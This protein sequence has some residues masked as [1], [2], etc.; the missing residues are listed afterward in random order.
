MGTAVST[1]GERASSSLASWWRGRYGLKL[2]FEVLICGV[3]LMI[4]RTIRLVNKTDLRTAFSNAREI[5]RFE[6]WLG[7]P[8]EDDLQRFLLDNPTLIKL[9]NH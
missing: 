3:L 4:Y 8:F 7:L 5:V 9:L 2:L 6:E 1:G